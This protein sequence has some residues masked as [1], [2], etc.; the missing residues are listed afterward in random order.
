M[1]K[2]LKNLHDDSIP[3]E[4]Y[5]YS[6]PAY[7]DESPAILVGD[8]VALTMGEIGETIN[9]GDKFYLALTG[10]NQGE[11]KDI[12]CIRITSGM[13]FEADIGDDSEPYSFF[14]GALCGIH[15]NEEGKSRALSTNGNAAF[16]V[17]DNSNI[18]NG[19]VTVVAL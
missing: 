8:I 17:L 12:K 6:A 16:E 3:S 5:T 10:K 2:Y 19:K 15:V 9:S 18:D 14:V 4:V 7:Y 13:V 11:T 1:F